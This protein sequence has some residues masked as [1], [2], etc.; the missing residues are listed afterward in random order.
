L[1]DS[2]QPEV[3]KVLQDPEYW[4]ALNSI[5]G[6]DLTVFA[7]HAML[8]R[9]AYSLDFDEYVSR[10]S[11]VGRKTRT[12]LASTFGLEEVTFP[13][14]LFFQVE[15]DAVLGTRLVSLKARTKEATY[16][17]IA[18]LLR[19]TAEAVKD[20]AGRPIRNPQ[21]AFERIE[22]AL[23][24]REVSVMTRTALKAAPQIKEWLDL[25]FMR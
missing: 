12:V 1:H 23:R 25:I 14:L 16:Q 18:D 4:T 7:V 13:A 6:R 17:E 11:Q 9:D 24:G 20:S 15:N 19:T 8:L 21:R 22:A 10:A 3:S 2:T 5:S